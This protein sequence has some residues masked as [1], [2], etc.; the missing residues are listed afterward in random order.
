MVD[1]VTVPETDADKVTNKRSS[2]LTGWL[3]NTDTAAL[4]A[5]AIG[6][7]LGGYYAPK[8]KFLFTVKFNFRTLMSGIDAGSEDLA[9][10]MYDLKTASRPNMTVNYEDINFYGYRTNVA[11]KL[12][13]GTVR[14]SFYDDS[15][16]RANDLLWTYMKSI[17][18]MTNQSYALATTLM[19]SN[20]NESLPSSIGAA[21]SGEEDSPID[22]MIVSHH[23]SNGTGNYVTN[24]TYMNPK[25][26]T[27]EYDEL[28]MSSSD[29]ATISAVFKFDAV[30]VETKLVKAHANNVQSGGPTPEQLEQASRTA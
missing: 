5:L 1:K 26:E 18:P 25:I 24:Y 8:L 6:N 12:T 17:S 21:V 2:T 10:I 15:A 30:N 11:T 19:N 4:G 3:L 16:N 22:S 27:V 14:L 13:V 20:A 23:Y 28:D 29:A 9:S 7:N